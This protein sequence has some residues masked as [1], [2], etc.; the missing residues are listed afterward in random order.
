[1][2]P[3]HYFCHTTLFYFLIFFQ[4]QATG[5]PQ[6]RKQEIQ[7][8]PQGHQLLAGGDGTTSP[9]S[10]DNSQRLWGHQSQD[11]GAEGKKSVV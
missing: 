1:M 11:Q 6:R 7:W 9:T 5:R 3:S 8:Y 10:S 4:S 2:L